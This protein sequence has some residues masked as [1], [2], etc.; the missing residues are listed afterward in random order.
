MLVAW[1][2]L[3]RNRMPVLKT[4]DVFAPGIALGHAIGRVGCFAAGCCWGKPTTL[5]WGI[6]FTNPLAAQL[7]GT[8]LGVPLHPTQLYEMVLEI[9]NFFLL[10]W[11][12]GRKRFNGEVIGT[13][14]F[15]YGV[16]R[17]FLD[18]LRDHPERDGALHGVMSTAQLLSIGLVIAGGLLWLRTSEWYKTDQNGR[19]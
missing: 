6:T 8:P 18:L 15:V 17:Y 11:L 9:A 3:R 5:P 7:V 12:L 14:M 4:C 16:A 2:Y 13:Y 19:G 10:V 1:W